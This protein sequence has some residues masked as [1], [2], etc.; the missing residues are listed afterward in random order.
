M[1]AAQR[2]K[3][4]AAH[5]GLKHTAATKKKLC[6]Q[7]RRVA[8]LER[9]LEPIPLAY[10]WIGFLLAD[11]H[12]TPRG[13]L[14]LRIAECDKAHLLKYGRFIHYTGKVATHVGSKPTHQNDVCIVAANKQVLAQLAEFG[15]RPR[16]T[17]YPPQPESLPADTDLMLSLLIGFIDGD[18]AIQYQTGRSDCKLT[19]KV[20]STWLSI[21]AALRQRVVSIFNTDMAEPHINK[22]GYAHWCMANQRVLRE[23]KQH[24]IRLGLPML[25]RKWDKIDLERGPGRGEVAKERLLLAQQLREQD[26]SNVEIAKTLHVSY[27]CIEAMMW[28]GKLMRR[29]KWVKLNTKEN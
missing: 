10:Y 5:Q 23:L 29:Q 3:I 2:Q 22:Q 15:L 27:A 24:A 11:G 12:V 14:R 19:I 8:Q 7:A 28:R 13:Q 25:A 6:A 17:Y 18:G 21:L 9:L 20:H 26:Y 4:S 1:S 16:K